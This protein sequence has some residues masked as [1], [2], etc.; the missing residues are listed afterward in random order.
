MA[1]TGA[2]ALLDAQ[3]RGLLPAPEGQS[4][5]GMTGQQALRDARERGLSG[6]GQRDIGGLEAFGRGLASG[7]TFNFDDELVGLL[8]GDASEWREAGE[9]S[10]EAHPWFYYPGMVTGAFVPVGAPLKAFGLGFKGAQAA[11]GLG[12]MAADLGRTLG[13]MAA[14]GAAYGQLSRLGAAEG[15]PGERIQESATLGNVGTDALMGLGFGALTQAALPLG[16][17]LAGGISRAFETAGIQRGMRKGFQRAVEQGD[18]GAA[19]SAA[20]GQAISGAQGRDFRS[21]QGED[22]MTSELRGQLT[23]EAANLQKLAKDIF[24]VDMTRSQAVDDA[25]ARGWLAEALDGVHGPRA[26]QAARDIMERQF[27]QMLGAFPRVVGPNATRVSAVGGAEN[28]RS[29]LLRRMEEEQA[30]IS[31]AERDLERFYSVELRS[32]VTE[33]NTGLQSLRNPLDEAAERAGF[34]DRNPNDPGRWARLQTAEQ[35][36]GRMGAAV[37]FYDDVRGLLDRALTARGERASNAVNVGLLRDLRK[38]VNEAWNDADKR[39]QSGSISPSEHRAISI[40]RGAVVNWLDNPRN[41]ADKAGRIWRP[42][43]EHV[44]RAVEEAGGPTEQEIG[45]RRELGGQHPENQGLYGARAEGL[46]NEALRRE[47]EFYGFFGTGRPDDVRVGQGMQGSI[48]RAITDDITNIL[49]PGSNANEALNTLIGAGS[50]G[51]NPPKG[52]EHTMR[53]IRER[54]GGYESPEW[55]NVQLTVLARFTDQVENAL[56][57]DN[58]HA[59]R[60]VFNQLDNFLDNHRRFV[61]EVF[62]PSQIARLEQL[63]TV[64][65]L[66]QTPGPAASGPSVRGMMGFVNALP[67]ARQATQLFNEVVGA[68]FQ[69][70]AETRALPVP[71]VFG[72]SVRSGLVGAAGFGPRS[73]AASAGTGAANAGFYQAQAG[74]L[75]SMTPEEIEELKRQYGVQ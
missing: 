69:A 48:G 55:E 39:F 5:G 65:R 57:R 28:L 22:R 70:A 26:Q 27:G 53:A 4:A 29:A 40:M 9:Q 6:N 56:Q 71:S 24:G 75:N 64:V 31:E 16:T 43:R 3:R 49:K 11:R 32:P 44:R 68:P 41:F 37:Q 66:M 51:V 30:G 15:T 35:R 17:H 10:R 46:M 72:P 8:G 60:T 12:G 20:E 38:Q 13:G 19:R 14:G 25:I 63:R 33:R 73:L 54:F 59:M 2:Q 45:Y 74:S 7:V 62:T 58:V 47:R 18:L 36:A 21:A 1:L 52:A 67:G 34:L 23:G 61:S 42:G 50:R